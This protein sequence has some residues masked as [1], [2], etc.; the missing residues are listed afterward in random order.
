MSETAP[1]Y[2][3]KQ[4]R[5]NIDWS[6]K[7]TS[8]IDIALPQHP[9]RVTK[10]L[11]LRAKSR[12]TVPLDSE[13][14][15]KYAQHADAASIYYR[16]NDRFPRCILW[17]VLE[18]WQILSLTS[19]DFT[20]PDSHPAL[21]KTFRFLFPEPIQ[22]GTVGFADAPGRDELV[23]YALTSGGVLYTLSLTPAF[24]QQNSTSKRRTRTNEFCKTFVPSTF[25]LNTP[26]ALFAVNH[27]S[28]AISLHDGNILRLDKDKSKPESL[29]S[30]VAHY[31]EKRFSDT[32]YVDYIKLK[33]PWVGTATVNYG[34][35]SVYHT[36]VI[37]AI[38]YQQ[39]QSLDSQQ[40]PGSVRPLLITVSVDHTL[41]V[42]SLERQTLLHSADLLNEP[43]P[44][45]AKM[46]TW[47]DPSPSSLLRIIDSSFQDDHLFY[48]V[49][50][51]TATTGKFKFWVAVKNEQGDFG[52]LVDLYPEAEFEAGPP[53]GTAPWIISEFRVTP[54]SPEEPSLF[55]LWVLWKSD[56]NFRVQNIQ[57]D[58]KSIPKSW[59]QWATAITDP[60]HEIPKRTASL[61]TSEDVTDFWM[62][63]IFYPGRFPDTVLESALL[64]YE[65][66]FAYNKTDLKNESLEARVTTMVTST[67]TVKESVAT[68]S[69]EKYNSDL[70]LQWER[71]SRLCTELDKAR[72]EALSLVTDPVSGYVWTVNVDGITALR[73]C[74]EPEIIKHNPPA[75]VGNNLDIL[76][77]RNPKRLG[78]GLKDKDLADAI[79][80]VGVADE[81]MNS[82]SEN[83]YDRCVMRLQEEVTRDP[84]QSMSD[85]MEV[86]WDQCLVDEVSTEMCEK[87]ENTIEYVGN[88]EQAF[89]SIF[90]SLYHADIH[91]TPARL[92]AFGAKVLVGGSQEVIHVNH[93]LLFSLVFLLLHIVYC[94]G[95]FAPISEPEILYQN[96]L[97]H[98]REYEILN[99]MARNTVP[100]SRQD[101]DEIS[102]ALTELTVSGASL[103]GTEKRGSVLQLVLK[104]MSGPSP[105]GHGRAGSTTLSFCVRRFLHGLGVDRYGSGVT[106]VVSALLGSGS[107]GKAMEFSKFLQ[108]S[109]WDTYMK[110]RVQLGNQRYETAASFFHKAA[111]GMAT[112]K[113]DKSVGNGSFSAQQEVESVIGGGL[114]KYYFHIAG[115]FG[116]A[117]TPD[118]VVQFCNTALLHANEW[119][120]R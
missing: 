92:T 91:N 26:H 31:V 76:S 118:Y 11:T 115:L 96:L 99:W 90:S 104:Q 7:K 32:R 8:S 119:M 82:L 23:V 18:D 108:S 41:K 63:W 60:V 48:L 89:S 6:E 71:F 80:L 113:S 24:F 2:L 73:E 69:Y 44:P 67:T 79:L 43:Q 25:T 53:S 1:L 14:K 102:R 111:F 59:S 57:F 36:T 70:N 75:S 64:L 33:M 87:I 78:A 107:A 72:G 38:T 83:A 101:G 29:E 110:G 54:A 50:L 58:I 37:S 86:L 15:F 34:E 103:S 47:L 55:D 77:W 12:Q 30:T 66:N 19:V 95:N 28:L 46:K 93:D 9:G 17:R 27:E 4:T 117:H 5:V 49:T 94:D 10:S 114:T 81:L 105:T 13:E 52:G 45:S 106:N 88:L 120:Y 109:C 74:T 42:W 51:S 16:L 85:L 112:A 68:P 61:Q 98:F 84:I 39:S 3:Y 22:P 65:E 56:T 20:K 97:A 35:S 40:P 62:N 21:D 116:A 100:L